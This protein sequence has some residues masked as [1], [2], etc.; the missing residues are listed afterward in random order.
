MCSVSSPDTQNTTCVISFSI[1]KKRQPGTTEKYRA[2]S[3]KLSIVQSSRSHVRDGRT[4]G[5]SPARP[6]ISPLTLGLGLPLSL[7]P[8][9][10]TSEIR[11]L[12]QV[13]FK[14]LPTMKN[15]QMQDILVSH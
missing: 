9:F 13:T 6:H 1:S 7:G 3:D 5:P 4:V 15:L 14:D 8:S 11:S 10:A 12:A 2:S